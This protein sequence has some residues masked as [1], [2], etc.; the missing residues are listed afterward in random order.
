MAN[1]ED[2]PVKKKLS[3]ERRDTGQTIRRSLL[4]EL[5]NHLPPK[6]QRGPG[7]PG[8]GTLHKGIKVEM[9]MV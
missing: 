1:T 3:L 6:E 8:V 9:A 5:A 4:S 2:R 7:D